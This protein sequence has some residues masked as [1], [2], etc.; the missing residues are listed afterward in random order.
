MSLNVEN[1][2][3]CGKIYIKNNFG[4]CSSCVKDIETEYEKCLQFLRENRT[5]TIQELSDGTGVD[6]KQIVKFIREGRISIK[7]NPNMTYECDICGTPIRKNNIC[8]N[9]RTRLV[10]DIEHLQ[11]DEEQ[12][13]IRDEQQSNAVYKIRNRPEDRSK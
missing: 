13:K 7:D 8:D 9:C 5:C 10:K 1:C 11:G 12:K 2:K 6:M 4:M 3:R